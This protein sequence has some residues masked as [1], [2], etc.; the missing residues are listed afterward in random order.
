MAVKAF[1]ANVTG[2]VQG[3]FFRAYTKEK[4][5]SLNLKGY[6]RN[7]PDGSVEVYAEGESNDLEKLLEFLKVGSPYSKVEKVNVYYV[8]PERKYEDFRIIY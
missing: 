2:K 5:D 8:E 7:M 1:L 6:V 4:A 3:V